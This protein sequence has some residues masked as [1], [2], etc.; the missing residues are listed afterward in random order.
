[1]AYKLLGISDET[2]TC[3]V[4][5]KRHLK[6]IL[7]LEDKETNAVI[8]CGTDCGSRLLYDAKSGIRVKE[9]VL[10]DEHKHLS[11]IKGWRDKGYDDDT[12]IKGIQNKIGYGVM[13][14]DGKVVVKMSTG[15]VEV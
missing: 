12:I 5:G 9:S 1:M 4:C 3:E 13:K 15:Y 14:K 7:V 6:R 8:R 2:D 11:I 10:N